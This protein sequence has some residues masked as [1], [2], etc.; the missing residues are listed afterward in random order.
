M[1]SNKKNTGLTGT[2]RCDDN[3]TYYIRQVNNSANINVYWYGESDGKASLKNA[4]AGA[5][6][7]DNVFAGNWADLPDSAN[8]LHGQITLKVGK[9]G[10]SFTRIAGGFGGSYWERVETPKTKNKK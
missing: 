1:G 10:N 7:D 8:D 9:D 6:S 5:F 4:F 3:S 2:W